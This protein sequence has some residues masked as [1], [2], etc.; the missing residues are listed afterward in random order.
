MEQP[1]ELF[2]QENVRPATLLKK[3]FRYMCFTVNFEN[4]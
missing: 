4:F 2:Y 3:R 1:P